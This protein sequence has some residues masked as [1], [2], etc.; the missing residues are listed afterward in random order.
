MESAPFFTPDSMVLSVWA[1]PQLDFC[2]LRVKKTARLLN[3]RS[4]KVILGLPLDRPITAGDLELK[5]MLDFASLSRD[6]ARPDA[7]AAP[8]TLQQRPSSA[9]ARH[10]VPPVVGAP[11]GFYC[12]VG[13]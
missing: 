6:L 5:H 4:A 9:R 11:V 7:P 3:Q 10:G 13:S 2:I 12:V 1:L 8:A